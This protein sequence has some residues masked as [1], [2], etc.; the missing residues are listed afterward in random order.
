MFNKNDMPANLIP[1]TLVTLLSKVCGGCIEIQALADAASDGLKEIGPRTAVA[2]FDPIAIPTPGVLTVE[3]ANKE[4]GIAAL[5]GHDPRFKR[6]CVTDV[7]NAPKAQPGDGTTQ[8]Q[9]DEVTVGFKE[10]VGGRDVYVHYVDQPADTRP[11]NGLASVL[12]GKRIRGL[13]A[14]TVE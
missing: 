11:V 7:K 3:S 13:A 1:H 8:E 9:L 12:R 14:I 5:F 10:K 4:H 6:V 2:V